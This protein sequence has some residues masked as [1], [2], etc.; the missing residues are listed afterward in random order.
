M[1]IEYLDINVDD[2]N[3]MP[4]KMEVTLSGK[5]YIITVYWNFVGEYFGVD[6]Y[7][8]AG[9]QI[10]VGKKLV[11]GVGIFE[12]VDSDGIPENADL[13]PL[14]ITQEAEDTGITYNNF[15]KDIKLFKAEFEQEG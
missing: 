9:N 10:I 12:N 7:D 14:A 3:K 1:I 5:D 2:I 11:I 13:I 4:D 8:S 15:M 6:I